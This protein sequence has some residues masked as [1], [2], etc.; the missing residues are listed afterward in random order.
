MRAMNAVAIPLSAESEPI[1]SPGRLAAALWLALV[2]AACTWFSIRMTRF[3][4]GVAAFWVAN[5]L[6]AGLLLLSPRQNWRWWFAA[7]A[8]GQVAARLLHGSS[9]LVSLVVV[10]I[11][12]LESGIVAAWVRRRADGI[13]ARSL[14][15]TARDAMVATLVA[16]AVSATLATLLLAHSMISTSPT[17]TWLSWYSAHVLGMV[18]VAT[19]TVC[20]LQPRVGLLGRAGQRTDF[21]LCAGLLA[22]TCF[23]VFWQGRY[24]LLFLTYLPLMLM[25]WR[26]GLSGMML[27]VVLIA[28]F[29]GVAAAQGHG[30]FALVT[31]A[32]GL[33]MMLFW[34]SYVAAGCL[35]AYSTALAMARRR[36]LERELQRSEA[37][38]RGLAEEAQRL[39]RFDSL[40]GL[41]NR[42]HFEEEL[43]HAVARSSRNGNALMLLALD[44]DHF[45]RINDT[46]GHA[47]GDAVLTE[48]ARRIRDGV[49]DVDLV[50][51]MGGDEF[52]VLVEYTATAAVGERIAE[53]LLR[54]LR[55]SFALD[56]GPVP[57]QSSIG[58]GLHHPVRSGE[59]L[60]ALADKALYEAKARGRGTWALCEG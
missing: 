10:A 5:G 6:L 46:L 36:K 1:R 52:V 15:R 44:L 12:L 22:A 51:R 56:G 41:A 47:A 34:Q 42:R 38:Y 58:I 37:R 31:G 30:P 11:N 20:T 57:V 24:P 55:P 2:A 33:S 26:H 29:S 32:S 43:A 14:G 59:Q 9:L 49:F 28:G 19:L 60:K 3:D 16:C 7:A 23:G 54:E 25:V 39:A 35:L 53:H 27:G 48:F 18:I 17:T 21:A 50:A 8:V 45:K 40:T 4:G 13:E